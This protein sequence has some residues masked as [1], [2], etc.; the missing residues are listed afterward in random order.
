MSP[1]DP[2][3]RP[4]LCDTCAWRRDVVTTR[5][6]FV[7]CARGIDDPAFAKYPRLPVIACAGYTPVP[8]DRQRAEA[9]DD[10]V[11]RKPPPG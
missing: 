3:P 11:V 10:E 4:G 1:V 2:A 5:S 8:P 6:R 7:L 9:G